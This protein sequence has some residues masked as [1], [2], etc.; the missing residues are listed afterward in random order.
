[1]DEA[2]DVIDYWFGA[3]G[4]AVGGSHREM[5]FRGGSEVDA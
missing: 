2:G 4:G 5:W 3:P 1:M